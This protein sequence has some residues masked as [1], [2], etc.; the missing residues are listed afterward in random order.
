MHTYASSYIGLQH[1]KVKSSCLDIPSRPT[2]ASS[3]WSLLPTNTVYLPLMPAKE[4]SSFPFCRG[5]FSF[6]HLSVNSH[7]SHPLNFLESLISSCAR[8]EL[9]VLWIATS[10]ADTTIVKLSGYVT[11]PQVVQMLFIICTN[12]FLGDGPISNKHEG[13]SWCISPYAERACP[14]AWKYTC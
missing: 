10:S 6:N 7:F 4:I 11:Y 3:S 5:F 2:L 12:I 13:S 8:P 9:Q 14:K 1:W